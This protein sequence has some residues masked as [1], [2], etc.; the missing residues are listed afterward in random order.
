LKGFGRR[1]F[2]SSRYTGGGVSELREEEKVSD[3]RIVNRQS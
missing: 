2:K 1:P 3:K